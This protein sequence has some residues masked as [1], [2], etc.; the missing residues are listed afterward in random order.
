MYKIYVQEQEGK[1]VPQEQKMVKE[2]RTLIEFPTKE[3]AH[4]AALKNFTGKEYFI[5]KDTMANEIKTGLEHYYKGKV[6]MTMDTPS[7][8]VAVLKDEKTERYGVAFINMETQD[9]FSKGGFQLKRHSIELANE[10]VERDNHFND[11]DK[12]VFKEKD[13]SLTKVIEREKVIEIEM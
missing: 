10:T 5:Y 11:P 13:T 8:F 3:D 12:L 2:D 7:G 6:E 1:N 9:V 4:D